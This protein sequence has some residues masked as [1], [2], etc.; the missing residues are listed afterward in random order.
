MVHPRSMSFANQRKVVILREV[1]K[2]TWASICK[3]VVNL[4]G[5]SP[6]EKQ[7]RQVYANM[8]SSGAP[9][10]KYCFS[11]CGRKPWKCTKEV[12]AFLVKKLLSLRRD[13]VCTST[14][15]QREL[16]REQDIRLACSTI[17]KVLLSKGYRWLPRG[18]KPKYSA[19]D[20]AMRRGFAEEVVAMSTRQLGKHLTMAM[21]GVVLTLPPAD[22]VHRENY[23][24]V[25]ESHM[26]RKRGEAAK[27]E[28]SGQDMYNKQVP[29]ARA[30]PMW[31]GIGPG[32]F[33]IV[34]F[35]Q[36]KKVTQTEWA[37]VVDD[38]KLEA[39]CKVTRP[40]KLGGP[41]R[42]LC[43]NESFLSATTSRAA[44]RKARVL[45]WQIPPRSPDLN[46]VEKYWGWLRAR[47]REKD[48]ADLRAKRPPL[49]RTAL[50][51]RV[52]SLIR[53]SRGKAVAKSIFASL[54]GSCQEVLR[55]KGAA[56]RG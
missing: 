46:P 4:Q 50:K 54:R 24:R 14:T 29:P 51:A 39:A 8:R 35:H 38:G 41:W 49:Q 37:A 18:Q 31:G 52:R 22:P 9:R 40:D 10:K 33:G 23:C 42:L 16:L 53:S 20:R 27:P 28:L 36:R 6:S 11:K 3:K 2:L 19:A 34:M 45:L 26:W 25:G 21:D 43:D 7:C 13:F 47:L 55:K 30:V 48:L 32:G 15:L 1:S 56:T 12:R 44:H 17:R 5:G